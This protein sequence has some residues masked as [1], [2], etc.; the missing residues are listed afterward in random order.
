L[1][2]QDAYRL[3]SF[4]FRGHGES[5]ETEPYAFR[6]LVDDIDGMR[7]H[8]SG[9]ESQIVLC[10]GSFGGYLAQQY[11]I[12]YSSHVSNLVFRG[13]APSFHRKNT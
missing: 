3:L 5:S 8:F 6:Q 1:S 7:I 11:A 12:E 2:L 4:D 9:P 10:G 13:I